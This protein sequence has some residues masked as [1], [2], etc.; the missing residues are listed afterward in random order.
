MRLISLSSALSPKLCGTTLS[1]NS[2][3]SSFDDKAKP[4]RQF[5]R[6]SVVEIEGRKKTTSSFDKMLKISLLFC[7][8]LVTVSG[9]DE[10]RGKCPD[11][12][13]MDNFDWDKV[14]K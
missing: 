9:H 12:K 11:L 13:P 3:R 8:V 14:K 7:V 5:K 1:K 10:Y 2:T 6:S 4:D